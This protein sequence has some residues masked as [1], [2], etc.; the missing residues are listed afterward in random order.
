MGQTSDP[1]TKNNWIEKQIGIPDI[2]TVNN[3]IDL[4]IFLDRGITNGGH[5]VRIIKTGSTWT[6]IKYDYLIKLKKGTVTEKI[7]KVTR[8]ILK[9]RNWD[10]L[11]THLESLNILTLPNQDDIK[12][13]LRTEVT[14]KR[15]KGYEVLIV[16]DGESYDL[17]VRHLSS[18][19]CYSFYSPWTY[20]NKYPEVSEV[21]NYGEIISTLESGLNIK[22]R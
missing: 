15:G 11:W 1:L 20:S 14:T 10:S 3:E 17:N 12:D 16:N 4:R 9:S 5:V 19:R 2:R 13:K 21:K 7:N 18:T 8:T 22:F 6:G